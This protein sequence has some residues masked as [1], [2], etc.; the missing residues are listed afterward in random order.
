M[1]R[2][3]WELLLIPDSWAAT[4]ASSLVHGRR[5]MLTGTIEF[6]TP[7]R[8]NGLEFQIF[9]Y[10][11]KEPGVVKVEIEGPGGSM[12]RS[13]VHLG[14]VATVGDGRALA[15][16]VNTTALDRIA[17][18][19]NISIENSKIV[20]E[21][22]Y[23]PQPGLHAVETGDT[24]S[25]SAEVKVIREIPAS[26]LKAQ[27]ELA[28]PP[29]E[30]NFGLFRSAR[31][32]ESPVEEFMHLYHILLMFH[33]DDQKAVDTFIRNEEPAVPVTPSGNP[34]LA[35]KGVDETVYSRLRNEFA[36]KRKGVN[37]DNTKAEMAA[38]LNGLIS[39]ARRAIELYP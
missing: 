35:N 29:G 1:E 17:Y 4:I 21:H 33:N 11:P 3:W 13:I 8:G 2:A 14:S 25:F 19:Y 32:S 12:I 7:I 30:Q 39:L 23:D 16:R 31:L 28:S 10:D 15:A 18:F 20:S 24:V 37:L 26:H 22:L 6:R 9:S 34:K 27:M 5:A 36:H 38:R